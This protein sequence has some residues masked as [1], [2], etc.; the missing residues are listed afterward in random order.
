MAG[1]IEIECPEC[2]SLCVHG[3]NGYIPTAPARRMWS[4]DDAI[5]AA[6]AAG[7]AGTSWVMGPEELAMLLNKAATS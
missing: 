1:E 3:E 4:Q 7:F 6:H 2:G 5:K